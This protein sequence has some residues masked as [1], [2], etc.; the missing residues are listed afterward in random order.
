M[1]T[2]LKILVFTISTVIVFSSCVKKSRFDK[3]CE[4]NY[5]LQEQIKSLMS[6]T[7]K[8]DIVINELK[9]KLENTKQQKT[10]QPAANTEKAPTQNEGSFLNERYYMQGTLA[11]AKSQNITSV[12]SV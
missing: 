2:K 9:A 11:S 3:V 4:E 5:R 7:T 1:N 6:E 8:K 10:E 12:K